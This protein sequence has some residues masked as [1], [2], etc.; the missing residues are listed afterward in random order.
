MRIGDLNFLTTEDDLNA[1]TIRVTNAIAH[2]NYQSPQQYHD[3]ALLELA[4]EMR[5]NQHSRPACLNA[6]FG[7]PERKAIAVGWGLTEFFGDASEALLKVTLDLFK[8]SDC[9]P[10]YEANR[11]L[12]QGL[13]ES[14]QLCAGSH[15][16]EKDTCEGDSGGPLQVYHSLECMYKIVGVTSF[17][18]GCG[19]AGLPGVYARISHYIDWIEANAF[20]Y[21]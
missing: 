10:S 8:F 16:S 13:V 2:P 5:F 7:I 6:E 12:R 14:Q 17:G 19:T 11:K 4:E 18:K 1:Q 21:G 3:I 15:D 9:Q 20:R